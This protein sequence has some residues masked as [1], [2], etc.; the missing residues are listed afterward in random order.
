[1]I[2]VDAVVPDERWAAL[3][4][5]EAVARRGVE[6]ALAVS[7]EA[8]SGDIE[9]S[10]AFTDDATVHDLNRDW[11]GK[12][13]ATNVLSFPAPPTKSPGPRLLGDIVLAYE[14]VAHE[15]I[16][17]GKSLADHTMHLLV[18]GTLHLLGYD[19]ETD[20]E[21]A[22]MEALETKALAGMGIADP[23][24]GVAA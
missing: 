24:E 16:G 22:V 7:R 2:E 4:D 18:H 11:R 23:Y 21:A 14:T 9:I 12:D 8:P 6:A 1:V 5:P 20:S 17:E 15:A 19:H 13:K 10:V 3:G